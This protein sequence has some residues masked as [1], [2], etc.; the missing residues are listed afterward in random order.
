MQSGDDLPGDGVRE[1]GG[2]YETGLV[3]LDGQAP[4]VWAVYDP[5][6]R[7]N[8]FLRPRLD[9]WSVVEVLAALNA[10][11]VDGL[12]VAYRYDWSPTGDLLL[13]DLLYE[14][15]VGE[16]A[17]EPEVVAPDEDGLYSLGASAWVWTEE[18]DDLGIFRAVVTRD[19]TARERSGQPYVA[20]N[21]LS[22]SG[23]GTFEERLAELERRGGRLYEI[24][25]PDGV[26]MLARAADLL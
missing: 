21:L 14:S 17:Y 11:P 7:W 15:E 9:A 25:F 24:Q 22:E 23:R 12:P 10:E 16:D 2:V 13:W 6:E 1:G 20:R 8:G 5:D 3:S 19:G 26:W 18:R 4:V